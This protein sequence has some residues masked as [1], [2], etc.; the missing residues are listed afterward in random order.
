MWPNLMFAIS[1]L[2]NIL[3]YYYVSRTIHWK[4]VRDKRDY[5]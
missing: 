1:Q 3:L 2:T 5:G 4:D